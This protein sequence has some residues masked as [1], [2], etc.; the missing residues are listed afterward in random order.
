[1]K[2]AIIGSG[3]AGNVAA[4]KLSQQHEVTVYE[5]ASHIGGHT[6]THDIEY[7]GQHYAVDTGF[8]VF[9]Y[10]TYP[11]FIQLLE[12]LG[13]DV[14]P[15][16]MSFSVKCD[17]SGLEY[18]GTT[19]NSLFAQ[20]RNLISPRFYCLIR[21]ILRFNR[22]A[23]QFLQRPEKDISLAA[24]LQRGGYGRMFID[25]YLVPM[26][27]AIWS[28][29]PQQML[30]F[31]AGFF[32]RFFYNHGML[33][34]DDRP[35]WYVIRGG[36]REYVKKLTVSYADRIRTDCA[37]QSIRR[38][39]DAVMI[40][41]KGCEEERYDQ[42]FIATHSDQALS[43]L[44][45]ATDQERNVLAA[46]PYQPNEVVLHTDE[47]LLPKRRLAWAAWN[48]HIP[49]S[50]QQRVALSYDMNILQ[51]LKARATFCVSL[52]ST[53]LIDPSK[54]IKTLH[55]QHP[56]FT[57]A[58]VAAQAQHQ[59]INGTKRTYYCGAY[60]RFGFHEDGVISALDAVKHFEQ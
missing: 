12:E 23:V 42:L 7:D 30:D 9:N 19:L 20:R 21:D 36:S 29:S 24:F 39:D 56:V 10:K 27:A 14:Q 45:D 2:I 57:P 44:T 6:H 52:N 4:Y 55:Y 41:A 32:M 37:V 16:S 40:K 26:G 60:W 33:N 53:H 1:M 5:A 43:L 8:I 48:Y 3:I 17:Q 18:N 58:G 59:A 13:V 51:S 38:T 54:I 47:S 25:K 46:I 22:Q 15:S 35:S 49:A 11:N 50:P 28:S 34:I 31:P